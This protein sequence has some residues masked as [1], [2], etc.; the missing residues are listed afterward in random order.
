MD[1][2]DQVPP[3]RFFSAGRAKADVGHTDRIL[4]QDDR[5]DAH[6][7]PIVNYIDDRLYQQAID[8]YRF[9]DMP[10]DDEAHRL[11]LIAIEAIARPLFKILCRPHAKAA[12]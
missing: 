3:I 12:G 4:P 9:E 1:R 10:E 5:D 8:G 7:I 6:K 2:V 11:G